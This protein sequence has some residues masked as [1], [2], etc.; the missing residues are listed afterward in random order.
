MA[1]QFA[2]ELDIRTCIMASKGD[3]SS[4]A[5]NLGEGGA[6]QRY[7]GARDLVSNPIIYTQA[8]KNNLLLVSSV[9]HTMYTCAVQ[10]LDRRQGN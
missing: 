8:Y 1:Q 3:L 6:P 9:V 7:C 4:N 5:K 10:S 2:H